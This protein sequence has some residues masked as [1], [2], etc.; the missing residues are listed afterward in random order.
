VT[1]QCVLGGIIGAPIRHSFI[2]F[3]GDLDSNGPRDGFIIP[4]AWIR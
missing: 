4:A 3:G 1:G 2:D